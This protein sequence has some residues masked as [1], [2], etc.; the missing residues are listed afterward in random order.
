MSCPSP[1]ARIALPLLALGWAA[2]LLRRGINLFSPHDNTDRSCIVQ[3]A[4]QM[5]NNWKREKKRKETETANEKMFFKS[6]T[7]SGVLHS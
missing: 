7:K 1:L 3:V 5:N 2:L 6:F 4:D